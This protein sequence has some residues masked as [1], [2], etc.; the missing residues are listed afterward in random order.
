MSNFIDNP[1]KGWERFEKAGR[2]TGAVDAVKRERPE[3]KKDPNYNPA[4]Y[5][6]LKKQGYTTKQIKNRLK[7]MC[8]KNHG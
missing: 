2:P 8:K 6:A 4:V 3:A 5:E 1:M 7:K